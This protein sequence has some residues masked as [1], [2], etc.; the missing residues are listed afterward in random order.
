MHLIVCHGS[1]AKLV[2]SQLPIGQL[3]AGRSPRRTGPPGLG[4]QS[5][6]SASEAQ[7]YQNICHPA[8]TMS[9]K[10]KDTLPSD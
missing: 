3:T 6:P 1:E 7:T 2:K 8:R 9:C 10:I 5:P 4:C